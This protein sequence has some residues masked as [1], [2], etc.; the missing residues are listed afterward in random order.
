MSNIEL[1]MGIILLWVIL[2]LPGIVIMDAIPDRLLNMNWFVGIT[3]WGLTVWG[4]FATIIAMGTG[5]AYL[6]GFVNH[7]LLDLFQ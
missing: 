5:L 7:W 1:G 2:I 6:L 3:I 4:I